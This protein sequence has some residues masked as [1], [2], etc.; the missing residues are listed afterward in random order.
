MFRIISGE[1]R[2]H[3]AMLHSIGAAK[4]FLPGQKNREPFANSGVYWLSVPMEKESAM[5]MQ[6][7]A[8][9]KQQVLEQDT[10]D[11]ARAGP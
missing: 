11:S 7:L 2:D 4:A 9:E 8:V 5:I 6:R 10:L 3:A 1:N